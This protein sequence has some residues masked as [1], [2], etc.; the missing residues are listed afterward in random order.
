MKF[1]HLSDC[2]IGGWREP[3]LKELN[4]Q[5]FKRSI[6]ICVEKNVGFV[7]ISGD[8]FNTSLPQIDTVS[9]AAH[10]LNKLKENDIDVYI[11]P[12]SHDFSP[13]GK[14]MLDV[15][16]KAGL[17][18][19]VYKF[20]DGK[21][22]FTVDKT[23]TKLTGMPGYRGGLE[24]YQYHEL[25]NKEE[26]A[27][28]KG[29]KIFL[30]HTLLSEFKPSGW[31]MVDSEPI[32]R[33]PMN[34]NY[35]AGGHPHFV[36]KTKKEGYG[37]MTYPGALFPNNFKELEEC[38]NGGFFIVDDKLNIEYI[39][40]NVKD[41]ESLEIDVNSMHPINAQQKIIDELNKRDLNDKIVTLR[42]HGTLASGKP[43]DI[44]FND[45][46]ENL[47][48]AYFVLKNTSKLTTKE[49]EEVKVEDGNIDNIEEKLIESHLG[50]I[51]FE[52]L[53]KDEEKKL[54]ENLMK[55]FDDEKHEGET[56][57][58]F[59]NRLVESITKVMDMKKHWK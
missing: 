25:K 20:K 35:Y 3:E 43:S 58:D 59:E 8:L 15:L 9:E 29:F 39:K 48:Q 22:E 26:L 40:V 41:V 1:A 6:D 50:Q 47:T 10:A 11:I 46:I 49:L 34:F 57:T 36:M 44:K 42:I 2:H 51:K 31:E 30:F 13:S 18:H 21:L 24:K 52:K 14:T 23:G 5:A 28:E 55:S 38:K 7:I 45:I 12:G 33:L 37:W 56:N 16:E 54:T 27:N 53:T 19:N 32:A 17:C 4:M